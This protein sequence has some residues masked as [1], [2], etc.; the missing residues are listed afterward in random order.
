MSTSNPIATEADRLAQQLISE[1]DGT[2][3][4]TALAAEATREDLAD[5]NIP[6]TLDDGVDSDEEFKPRLLSEMLTAAAGTVGMVRL[7]IKPEINFVLNLFNDE[8]QDELVEVANF[9]HGDEKFNVI[10]PLAKKNDKSGRIGVLREPLREFIKVLSQMLDHN[11]T[12]V[13][14]GESGTTVIDALVTEFVSVA[15]NTLYSSFP[16]F[17]GRRAIP[18]ENGD[19]TGY[20]MD[21]TNYVRVTTLIEGANNLD[22]AGLVNLVEVTVKFIVHLRVPLLIRESSDKFEKT[23][24]THFRYLENSGVNLGLPTTIYASFNSVDLAG[25]Q[26]ANALNWIREADP[27]MEVLSYRNA[28]Q[29]G[30]FFGIDGFN[31]DDYADALFNGGD[32]IVAFNLENAGE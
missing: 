6:D 27:A 3:P 20:L 22:D 9:S 28:E 10:Q 2:E 16:E 32:F 25:A 29:G 19:G 8:V 4:L 24:K 31:A 14:S 21:A 18:V 13:V 1:K 23:M 26:V 15:E 30:E 7:K 5:I 12:I 17:E 11:E